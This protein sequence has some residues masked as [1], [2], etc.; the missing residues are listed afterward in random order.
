[1]G[2]AYP[3]LC[4]TKVIEIRKGAEHCNLII[5]IKYLHLFL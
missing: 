1:M 2:T 4:S 3:N 5:I